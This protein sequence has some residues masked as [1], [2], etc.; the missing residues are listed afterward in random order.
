MF[1]FMRMLRILLISVCFLSSCHSRKVNSDSARISDPPKMQRLKNIVVTVSADSRIFFGD[2]NEEVFRDELDSVLS[3]RINEVRENLRDST[4]RVVIN[5]DTASRYGVVF[6]I[7]EAAS[8][9]RAKVVANV[10]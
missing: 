3:V 4:V 1:V 8:K 5:A 2:N 10:K 9:L 6:S 7:I